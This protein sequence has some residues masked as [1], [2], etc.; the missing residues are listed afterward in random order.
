MYKIQINRDMDTQA[1][2]R[3]QYAL[4]AKTF[5]VSFSVLTEPVQLLNTVYGTLNFFEKT[6]PV[7]NKLD[8]KI[9]EA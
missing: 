3:F 4:S 9:S 8:V 2:P 7:P 1:F 6:V 5:F